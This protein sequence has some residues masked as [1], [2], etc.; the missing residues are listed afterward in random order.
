MQS[1][2]LQKKNDELLHKIN[3]KDIELNA[4]YE[5]LR[6]ELEKNERLNKILNEK[7][8]NSKNIDF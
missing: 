7:I 8:K 3:Y 4:C 6:K 2:E 1:N 5:L